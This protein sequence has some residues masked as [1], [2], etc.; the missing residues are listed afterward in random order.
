MYKKLNAAGTRASWIRQYGDI[1][2]RDVQ[3][4]NTLDYP[5]ILS[6]EWLLCM[7]CCA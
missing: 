6:Y 4:V 1:Q 5:D 2:V 3:K 7:G